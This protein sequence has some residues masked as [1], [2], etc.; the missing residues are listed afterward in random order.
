MSSLEGLR[1]WIVGDST[2]QPRR[3]LGHPRLLAHRAARSPSAAR[4]LQ[5]ARDRVA[6]RCQVRTTLDDLPEADVVYALRMRHERMDGTF[7]PSLRQYA[8]PVPDRRPAAAAQP[9]AHAPRPVNRGVELAAEVIDS[10]QSADRRAGRVRGRG[11]D[12]GALRAAGRP[13]R[14]IGRARRG[15][16][17]AAAGMS[18][19]LELDRAPVGSTVLI[20]GARLLDPRT[21][22]DGRADLLVRDGVVAEIGDAGAPH[23]AE[24]VEGEGLRTFP[25]FVDPRAPAAPG[26]GRGEPRL[27]TRAAAAAG[28]A[29]SSPSP[30]PA[31]WSSSAP[32]LRCAARAG[33]GRGAH[34]DRLPRR[35]HRRTAGR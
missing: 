29:R 18:R 27:G 4:P 23:G 28:S 33:P 16:D 2:A 15:R 19:A 1:I 6:R 32:V 3:A 34:P 21:G 13:R 14:A 11:A 22:L 35:D 5:S 30:T 8:R 7:M 12:G 10:P 17:R 24:L 25:A 31:P 26:R 9:T 20:R